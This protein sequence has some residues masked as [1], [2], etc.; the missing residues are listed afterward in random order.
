LECDPLD[1]FERFFNSK[2]D[3]VTGLPNR[4][5]FVDDY[6]GGDDLHVVLVNLID[7]K[8]FTDLIRALGYD[9]SETLLRTGADRLLEALPTG[10]P[11]YYLIGANFAFMA[12]TDKIDG[13]IEQ[14]SE[15]FS[16]PVSCGGIPVTIRF[17]L[18]LTVCGTSSAND[19]LR[20]ALAA[21]SDSRARGVRWSRYD[22]NTD[23]A[24]RRS[25]MLLADLTAA[26]EAEGQLSLHYQPKY[27][28]KTGLPTSTEA[29]LRWHHPVLG[30]IS[31]AE[32]IALA[33]A[34][35]HIHE[36]TE[37][38]LR[39][40]IPQAAQWRRAGLNLTVAVN[41]SPHNLAQ[42]GFASQVETI[43]HQHHL[44]PTAIE[45]EFTEGAV[46]SND[47]V[48]L[49][50]LRALRDLGMRI[51]I[52]DFGTGFANFSYMTSLPA[53]ILKIDQSFIRQISGDKRSA[54][55]VRGLIDM[56]HQL[57]YSVVAEGIENAKSYQQLAAWHC[58]EGQGYYM[59][60]PLDAA[61]F[62]EHVKA[63]KS[64]VSGV[65][66]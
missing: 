35:D 49:T 64:Y 31:P 57:G 6:T 16:R 17:A 44:E 63:G 43:L 62:F 27:D 32:F 37:W 11:L 23:K 26:V 28:L 3:P 53:D 59:S 55:V 41:V 52:D 66:V 14:I 48:V 29:L 61:R 2:Y 5:Q 21:S 20:A 51:A 22:S 54:L 45:L 34:T 8:S 33:E 9:Y 12:P 7:P 19:S 50:E 65:G 15:A 18:G 39:Q 40:A 46:A 24:Q 30:P 25:F 60:R 56:A 4:Q 42:R 58:D 36:L 1:R 10:L 38:V 13:I 47:E